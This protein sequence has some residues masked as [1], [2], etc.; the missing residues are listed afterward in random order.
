MGVWRNT[1]FCIARPL[2]R[3]L[4]YDNEPFYNQLST[5]HIQNVCY[6]V[7][8]SY[9][10]THTLYVFGCSNTQKKEKNMVDTVVIKR[11]W[12]R[13]RIVENTT[14]SLPSAVDSID[15]VISETDNGVTATVLGEGVFADYP[16]PIRVKVE[17]ASDVVDANSE[18]GQ[19]MI[20]KHIAEVERSNSPE[21]DEVDEDRIKTH[22]VPKFE[23]LHTMTHSLVNGRKTGIR[24]LIVSGPAGV[25]KSH[26]MEAILNGYLP[27]PVEDEA[28]AVE[29]ELDPDRVEFE[30]CRGAITAIALYM[31]LW[32]F[33]GEDGHRSMIVFDDCDSIFS[34]EQA[35]NL[36]KAALDTKPIRTISW[37][38]ESKALARLGIPN[39]FNFCGSVAFV[40]NIDFDREANRDTKMAEH[41]R[42]LISRSLFLDLEMRTARDCYLRLHQVARTGELFAR[43]N[44]EP[45]QEKEI[46]LFMFNK[47]D[48]LREM[49]LRMA[50]KIAALRASYP[51]EWKK[52]AMA[53]CM[54]K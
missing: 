28:E 52:M 50:V 1:Q 8:H 9:T 47:R 40:S 54:R 25:G 48:S 6:S 11:A 10:N 46:L 34:D 38:A 35:L 32:E 17:A 13:D 31:K 37:L 39:T 51:E 49:S 21:L 4:I 15:A 14:F 27:P 22:I 42:A 12:Y 45:E 24:S 7:K 16:G 53:L 26:G 36:L 18:A 30:F 5:L 29:Q 44:F 23:M 19:D 2:Q 43:W 41:R 3:I 33:R 20:R